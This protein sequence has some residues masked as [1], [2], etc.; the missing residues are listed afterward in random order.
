MGPGWK[1]RLHLRR[2]EWLICA[3][4]FGG[5]AALDP[6]VIAG[7][8]ARLLVTFFGLV[9][10]GILPTIS[11]VIGGMTSSGR[12]VKALDELKSEMEVAM[13]A[14][15][16]LF[17]LV[18]IAVA[19]LVALSLPQPS[20]THRI[21]FVGEFYARFLQGFVVGI[22]AVVVN[23]ATHIPTILRRSLDVRYRIA[24]E[25]AKRK[26]SENA[27]APATIKE[28]FPTHPDFGK[29]LRLSDLHRG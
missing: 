28:A 12:S 20:I 5:G 1:D 15:F 27:P 2:L 16:V 23:R 14:L 11:L 21:P 8:A 10:A 13:S 19:T 7:E 18:S 24:V 3:A 25:E 4:A 9:A 22:S 17:A 6:G 29:A 26:I